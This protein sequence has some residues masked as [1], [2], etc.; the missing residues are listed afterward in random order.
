MHQRRGFTLIELLVVIAIIAIL[1][2][3]LFPVFAKAR[4]KAREASCLSNVKQIA[5]AV[6][7]YQ[8][9]YDGFVPLIF[10]DPPRTYWPLAIFPYLGQ[11][12]VTTR[13][14]GIFGCPSMRWEHNWY[15][16]AYS[17]YGMNYNLNQRFTNADGSV[18]VVR[19]VEIKYPASTVLT[20][21]SRY[22]HPTSLVYYGWYRVTSPTGSTRY[23]HSDGANY[24]FCD[25]H[26]KRYTL[27]QMR[28]GTDA[29]QIHW[30][31]R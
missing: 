11:A 28:A 23:D 10:Y 31:W 13:N 30:D 7:M 6:L 18:R 27:E 3:I 12:V 4:E 5:L 14:Y 29:S 15:S 25:G 20:G 16:G 9:D 1:A 26:A 19:D 17:Q 21:E 22:Y 8:N 24:S 2:A